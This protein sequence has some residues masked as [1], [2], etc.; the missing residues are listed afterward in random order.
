MLMRGLARVW[1]HTGIRDVFHGAA[2]TS[3]SGSDGGCH[4]C[5]GA[6]HRMASPPRAAAA[7]SFLAASLRAQPAV[8]A[9]D[10]M[11][12]AAGHHFHQCVEWHR[13]LGQRTCSLWGRL[14]SWGVDLGPDLQASHRQDRE[15][16]HRLRGHLRGLGREEGGHE[17]H[18]R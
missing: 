5:P 8:V 3:R 14:R 15:V 13:A 1:Q 9:V 12:A 18:G 11:G 7:P 6:Q 4:V 10:A 2:Y 17:D 16:A